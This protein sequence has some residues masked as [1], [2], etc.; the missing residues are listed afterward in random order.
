MSIFRKSATGIYRLEK[1]L[2]EQYGQSKASFF[3][4][5]LL[6]VIVTAVL[7]ISVITGRYETFSLCVLTLILFMIPAFLERTLNADLPTYFEVFILIFIFSAQMLGE[8]AAFY[9]KFPWW[10]TMLHGTSGFI[11]AAFGFSIIDLLHKDE[12]LKFKLHPF[13]MAFNSFSFTMAIAVIW[14]F[15]EFAMDYFFGL[16]MQKDTVITKFQSVTLDPTRSNIPIVVDNIETVTINGEPLP[17]VGYLDIGLYDTIKDIAVAALGA[18]IFCI[19]AY[20]YIKTKGHNKIAS[21]FIPVK[22]N[23]KEEPPDI[24]ADFANR[25]ANFEAELAERR[26][27][28]DAELAERKKQ[29]EDE[30]QEQQFEKSAKN[31]RNIDGSTADDDPD[32]WES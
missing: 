25:I 9:I 21:L 27:A 8:L 24:E 3:A 13:Y 2:A 11:F 10:D 19:F 5:M 20:A 22:R 7:V 31:D 15:F 26:A 16:D 18:V 1:L 30:L 4:F 29:F 12:H 32:F 14:E 28:F 17:F 23:W 6:R